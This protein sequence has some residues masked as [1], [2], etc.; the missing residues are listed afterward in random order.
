MKINMKYSKYFGLCLLVL[1]SSCYV[2]KPYSEVE[3]EEITPGRRGPGS[4]RS[5]S[6]T[7]RGTAPTAMTRDLPQA[8]T[9]MAEDMER[10]GQ[11]LKD[12]EEK[13]KEEEKVKLSQTSDMSFSRSKEASEANEKSGQSKSEASLTPEEK[14]LKEKIKPNKY[15]KITVADKQYKIEVNKWEGD[16]LMANVLRQPKKELKF[17][18]N[19]IDAENLLERRFSKS[20]SDLFTI[21]A[22]VVGG[23]AVLLLFL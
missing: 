16:T 12:M 3:V 7:D 18:E 15:Y 22:Y 6:L 9:E 5:S 4:M 19:Q 17:H 14:S 2:Y 21:G 8:N 20:Y 1:L 10:K 11:A 23:A 13:A